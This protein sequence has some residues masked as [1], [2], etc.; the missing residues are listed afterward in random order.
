AFMAALIGSA[1][2]FLGIPRLLRRPGV[3]LELL[4]MAAF[5]CEN[6]ATAVEQPH[7]DVSGDQKKAPALQIAQGLL[8]QLHLS[9]PTPL[10]DTAIEAAVLLINTL[11]HSATYG[12]FH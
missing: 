12:T 7:G 9:V 6:A 8:D 11:S 1:L 2:T 10:L 3:T 4:H 5:V